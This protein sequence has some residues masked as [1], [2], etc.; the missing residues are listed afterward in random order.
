MALSGRS[1]TRLVLRRSML[2]GAVDQADRCNP[3]CTQQ[4]NGAWAVYQGCVWALMLFASLLRKENNKK[5]KY[6][7]KQEHKKKAHTDHPLGPVLAATARGSLR[8]WGG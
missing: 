4:P 3:F 1:Y 2:L 8:H 5:K 7:T 6:P